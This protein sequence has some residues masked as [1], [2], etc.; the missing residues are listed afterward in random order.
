MHCDYNSSEHRKR[1]RPATVTQPDRA[2]GYGSIRERLVPRTSGDRSA[3][4]QACRSEITVVAKAQYQI[5]DAAQ[6][7][8]QDDAKNGALAEGFGDVDGDDQ[9]DREI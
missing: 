2:T 8:Q 7:Q 5:P 9:G 4:A 6:Q 1:P 3:G